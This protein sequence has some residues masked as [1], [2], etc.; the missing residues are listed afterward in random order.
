MIMKPIV[1]LP[2]VERTVIDLVGQGVKLT[3][4]MLR[5]RTGCTQQMASRVLAAWVKSGILERRIRIPDK[6]GG[7]WHEYYAGPH[8]DEAKISELYQ[9]RASDLEIKYRELQKQAGAKATFM[10]AHMNTAKKLRVISPKLAMMWLDE[11]SKL[12]AASGSLVVSNAIDTT[13]VLYPIWS[14]AAGFNENSVEFL[15]EAPNK[16]GLFLVQGDIH[17][18]IRI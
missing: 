15:R 16:W 6:R 2:V 18:A 17:A 5:E 10:A 3:S 7:F 9:S 12:K 13:S 14:T 1:E 11:A 4:A 8:F